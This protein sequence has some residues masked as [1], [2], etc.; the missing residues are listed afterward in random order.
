MTYEYKNNHD[1]HKLV[2]TNVTLNDA[3]EYKCQFA[4]TNPKLEQVK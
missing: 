4:N 3:G 2:I 1:L